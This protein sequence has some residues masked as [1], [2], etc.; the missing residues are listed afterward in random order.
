MDKVNAGIPVCTN[1]SRFESYG[2]PAN[3]LD[4]LTIET[5]SALTSLKP[6]WRALSALADD[7][8]PCLTFEYCERAAV[9]VF[10]KGGVVNIAIVL[11]ENELLALWPVAIFHE[12][13]L[14][15]A[16]ALTCGS[17]EEY[18]GPLFKG[19]AHIDLYRDAVAAM[20]GVHADVLELGMVQHGSLL[21]EALDAYRNPGCGPGCRGAG[22]GCPVI[23]FG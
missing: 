16:R 19:R 7:C 14:R 17:G 20:R 13:F 18:G 5:Q 9:Q 1:I 21:H 6:A 15:I 12:K 3:R 22:A 2:Q 11:R 10:A 23:R 8:P 4:V